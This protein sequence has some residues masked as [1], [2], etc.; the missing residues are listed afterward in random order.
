MRWLNP[1]GPQAATPPRVPAASA[2]RPL[3]ILVAE[4]NPINQKITAKLLQRAGHSVE[5]ANDGREALAIWREQPFDLILMDIQ[6]PH[7]NGFECTAAIRS[8]ERAGALHVPIVALTA[9]A[10]A[11]YDQRCL[12]AGMDGYVAK[13]VRS[14]ALLAAIQLV[15]TE[16]AAERAQP[17][18][19]G[20]LAH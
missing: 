17:K 8:A 12:D 10:L 18:P 11:G 5:V 3:R 20:E 15:M 4:D 6:M 16:T 1:D 2:A 13:P 19:L 7:L 9:H 14:E